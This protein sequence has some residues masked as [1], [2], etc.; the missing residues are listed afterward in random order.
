MERPRDADTGKAGRRGFSR[1]PAERASHRDG[2]KD[3]NK[4]RSS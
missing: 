1:Y 4:T 3:T 2:M